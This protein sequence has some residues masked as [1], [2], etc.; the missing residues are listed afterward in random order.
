MPRVRDGRRLRTWTAEARAL[1]QKEGGICACKRS[2]YIVSF[3]VRMARS[4]LPF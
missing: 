1:A 2:V 4:S 3:T